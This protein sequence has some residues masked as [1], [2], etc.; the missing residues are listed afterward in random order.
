MQLT[1]FQQQVRLGFVITLFFVFIVGIISYT[2]IKGL[3][4]DSLWV[5]HSEQVLNLNSKVLYN[6]VEAE[7]AQR[8]YLATGSKGQL[9]L[10]KE[11]LAKVNPALK[12]LHNRV[13]DNPA[14]VNRVD[15]LGSL[16]NQKTADLKKVLDVYSK[17]GQESVNKQ[18]LIQNGKLFM[19]LVRSESRK[20][21][22]VEE[23]LLEIRKTESE[24][25]VEEAYFLF[26]VG[27]IIILFLFMLMFS[28]IKKNF[29]HQKLVEDDVRKTNTLLQTVS[30]ENKKRNWMLTGS[31]SIGQAIREEHESSDFKVDKISTRILTEMAKY[32][33]AQIGAVYMADDS[34]KQLQ[35]TGGYAFQAPKGSLNVFKVG[36]G[37]I[38]QAALD[39]K[40]LVCDDVADGHV[41]INTGMGQ[42]SPKFIVLQPLF[43]QGKLKGVI[44]LGF[45]GEVSEQTLEF[46]QWMSDTIGVEVQTA[47]NKVHAQELFE[48]TQQQAEE[49][50]SQHEELRTTNDELIRKTKLLQASE[51]ELRVQQEEL[52]QINSELEEK[53]EM[54]AERNRAVD[55]A[56]E[57][58]SLKAKE[59]EQTSKY[60]SE[61]L[62]NMSHELR[63]PLNSI[64]IL[65]RILS[66]NK[67]ANLNDEQIK[68]SSVIHNAGSDLLTLI[69][70]ILDLSKIESGKI[71]LT[72]ENVLQGDIQCDIELLFKEVANNKKVNFSYN[73]DE[74]IPEVLVSDRVRIEQILKNLLSNAFKFTPENGSV[75]VDLTVAPTEIEF[76]H[77]AL[78]NLRSE[79]EP[80]LAFSVTDTGIGI[81][82]DKQALIFEAFKQADGSTS[83]KYGGTGLGLSISR[84]L[85]NILG[86][87]IK[88]TSVPGKGS[89][90]TLYLP[91]NHSHAPT[92]ELVPERASIPKIPIASP[93]HTPVI[94]SKDKK[95]QTMLI[96]ED[97]PLFAE[98][99][100]NYAKERGFTPLLA[101]QGD[102]GL[103]LALEHLPDAI[104]LDIMLPVMDGWTILKRLK[105]DPKTRDIPVHMMSA[106]DEKQLKAVS[107]GAIGFLKKPIA[108]EK[109]DEAFD[110]LGGIGTSILNKVLIIEDHEIQ[111]DDLKN[112]LLGK[113]VHV[114]QAFNG[115]D[116]MKL[117]AENNDFDC[118]I[119]DLNL[120]DISGLDLLDKIKE[121]EG[122]GQIPVV[123]NTAMELDQD[124]LAR[125]MRHTHA[126]VLKNNKSNERLL[127][128]VHLFMNRVK[129]DTQPKDFTPRSLEGGAKN[130]ATLEGA[131]KNKLVLVVDDDMRNIFALTSALQAYDLKIEIANNGVEALKKL[132][133]N[134]ETH[135]VLMDIM[136]PEM[137]G[138]E[139]MSEI[140]KQNRFKKL[141]I[142]ALT[143]KAMKNDREKCI[144]AGANDY[145]SKPVDID[146]LLSLMRVWL[147]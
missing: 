118:I 46:L 58:I 77:P 49:L 80:V 28:F 141:P 8:G 36:E 72:I 68:Y 90:F 134:P 44:E 147:S 30:D 70:D 9:K 24:H 125:V 55:Q 84:E 127:D 60:K 18:R 63:T 136:M 143:A 123:I 92:P 121:Q 56:H 21:R 1:T 98:I 131:L 115:E 122:L 69:N 129:S 126:M 137:D 54:L 23:G 116:A 53:A 19:D 42:S 47:Q 12:E 140:R 34:G 40:T 75:T 41:K 133:E 20:I 85:S 59:L 102:T 38:G 103:E 48:K 4:K 93:T 104:V 22:E 81:P 138:Y 57:A 10:Y 16:V 94:K 109:L 95:G 13:S 17:E 145:I 67:Q 74:A 73:I 35:F 107:E 100:V 99:L 33:G 15:A 6:I 130:T 89:T 97:D 83:R 111:S 5:D 3:Q 88:V 66:E 96:V 32:L 51:E 52:R 71:D 50:E 87:E 113:K 86:G 64:L 101:K 7:N 124:R 82:E 62:A 29:E 26:I 2:S 117:L 108:K 27:A 91:V 105:E 112:Q 65:A 25:N 14:Q 39:R 37:L 106:A 110:L 11:S 119:L 132:E 142:I 146:K 78:Q 45:A 31:A 79:G 144:E 114:E 76:N 128:E 135:L 139:A 120:P 61:F 43:A